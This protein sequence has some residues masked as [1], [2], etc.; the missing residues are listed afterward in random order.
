LFICLQEFRSV[1]I[2]ATN[3]VENYDKAFE[4]RVRHLRFPMP[5]ERCRRGIW[6]KHLVPQLPLAEDVSIDQL[7][8]Y[9]NDFCGR[10]IKNAVIDAAVRAARYR[11][12]QIEL[13]DLVEAIDR[14]RAAR[15]TVTSH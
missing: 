8:M 11:K 12:S 5:D 13:Q 3:L 9:A 6:R 7:A 15:I 1:V 14:L 2:F 4:T 10:D